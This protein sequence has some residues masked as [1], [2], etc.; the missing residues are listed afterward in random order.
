MST[1][2]FTHEYKNG[3]LVSRAIVEICYVC[4][5]NGGGDCSVGSCTGGDISYRN[6]SRPNTTTDINA[7]H[8]RQGGETQHSHFTKK[9][10]FSYFYI[11]LKEK[12]LSNKEVGIGIIH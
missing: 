12:R 10:Y 9:L 4:G 6:N 8:F 1:Y 3:Q 5:N 2:L 11:Q 7:M